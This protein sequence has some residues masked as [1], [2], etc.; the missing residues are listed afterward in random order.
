MRCSTL[1]LAAGLLPTSFVFE[2]SR[3]EH[4]SLNQISFDTFLAQRGTVF[5]ALP[6][7]APAVKLKLIEA[8]ECQVSCPQ[9][10]LAKDAGNEKFSLL[11]HGHGPGLEQDTYVFEHGSIGRFSMFIVP[12]HAQN[13]QNHYYQA[14]FNRLPC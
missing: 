11:F 5:K 8:Q 7:S 2:P 3:T 12:V 4:L 10:H 6:K 14:V 9:P 1:T 13:D